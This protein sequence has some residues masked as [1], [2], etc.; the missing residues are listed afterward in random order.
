MDKPVS[1]FISKAKRNKKSK[2]ELSYIEEA[3]D[4]LEERSNIGG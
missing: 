3:S 4:N 2:N 1:K